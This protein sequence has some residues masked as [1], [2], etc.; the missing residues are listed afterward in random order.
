MGATAPCEDVG[1]SAV[2]G[3]ADHDTATSVTD[4]PPD[5]TQSLAPP[6]DAPLT[7]EVYRWYYERAFPAQWLGRWL[8][9][10][11]GEAGDAAAGFARA[12]PDQD[13]HRAG[14][15]R[16]AARATSCHGA[17]G[18]AGTGAA[19]RHRPGRVPGRYVA[20]RRRRG[21]GA[22]AGAGVAGGIWFSARVVGV[23]GAPRRARLGVRCA[24]AD[25]EPRGA[26]RHR[27][28]PQRAR[29]RRCRASGAPRAAASVPH[30]VVRAAGAADAAVA[31]TAPGGAGGHGRGGRAAAAMH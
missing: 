20:G 9:Y 24:S 22:G 21:G 2:G 17:D 28:L 16:G 8:S 4:S 5:S 11:G 30:R 15:E 18:G 23:L 27:P 19:V 12:R 14:A 29:Q 3:G 13:G 1:G 10:G 6:T 7:V 26:H 31:G 25:A